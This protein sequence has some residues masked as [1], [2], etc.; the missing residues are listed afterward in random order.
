MKGSVILKNKIFAIM[1]ILAGVFVIND[2]CLA[3]SQL[4]KITL[5]I[6]SMKGV[7][8]VPKVAKEAFSNQKY[9]NNSTFNSSTGKHY[10]L[11]VEL[12]NTENNTSKYK[13]LGED[14]TLIFSQDWQKYAG[15]TYYLNLKS[16]TWTIN[17]TFTTGIWYV[18]Y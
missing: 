9:W 10:N 2:I 18:S 7:Y 15:R 14:S 1:F 12:R 17:K 13:T 11:L 4:Q 6:P 5:D 3:V 8:M 16:G